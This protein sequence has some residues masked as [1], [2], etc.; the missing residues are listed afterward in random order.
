[1]N[2]EIMK[3]T[4]YHYRLKKWLTVILVNFGS[5]VAG[6][7]WKSAYKVSFLR[8]LDVDEQPCSLK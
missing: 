7:T 1:M 4:F 8:I 6:C 3:S 5:F 2:F